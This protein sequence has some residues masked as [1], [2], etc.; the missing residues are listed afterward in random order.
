MKKTKKQ[1]L[2]PIEMERGRATSISSFLRTVDPANRPEEQTDRLQASLHAHQVEEIMRQDTSVQIAVPTQHISGL[3]HLQRKL[4]APLQFITS[5]LLERVKDSDPEGPSRNLS[6]E[7]QLVS[8]GWFPA[9][10]LIS[11]GGVFS[12]SYSFTIARAGKPGLEI[13][14]L[15]GLLLIFA[16]SLV[17]LLSTTPSRF[18]RITIVCMAGI[19]LYSIKVLASP[20]YFSFFDE[21]LHWRTA[22]DILHTGHLFN[23]NALL[24]VSPYYPGLEIV[25]NAL[26]TL[27]GLDTFYAA[28]IVIGFARLVM[29]LSLYLLNEQFTSSPRIAGL[30]TLLYMGNPHFL[31]FDAQYAYESLA[32]PLTEFVLLTLAPYQGLMIRLNQLK[33]IGSG[34]LSTKLRKLL[35]HNDLYGM[36]VTT[37]IVLATIVVTHHVTNF[38]LDGLL[39]LWASTYAFL[40][41]LPFYRSYLARVA[42]LGVILSC[43]MFLESGNP[44]INYISSFL[45]LAF[46]ELGHII[47]GTGGAKQLFQ[48][49]TGQ[50]TA[51]WERILTVVS[52]LLVIS[53]LPVGLLCL[54]QRFRTNAL[55]WTFGVLIFCYP[56]VQIFRFTTSG[57]ELVDRSAA[58]LFIPISTVVSIVIAQLWPVH[59]FSRIHTTSLTITLSIIIIGGIVLGAGPSLALLPGPYMVTA[60]ARSIET[61][62]IQAATW[63]KNYLGPNKR[64]A[65]DRINQIL[66][67]TYGDQ[68]II[69]SIADRVEIAPIFLSAQFGPEQSS[70]IKAAQARY[71]VVDMRLSKALPL[72]GFYYEQDEQGAY[73]H[74]QPLDAEDLKKF[75][76]IPQINKVFD[77]GSI[78]I[79]DAEGVLNA[80]EK[81]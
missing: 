41:P 28:L 63:T 11:S 56:L 19:N 15:L 12:V 3:D 10:A 68:Q 49:Y 58:F 78:V 26:S 8:W 71:L 64:I 50:P 52:Q 32:L 5:V 2:I 65:T 81:P 29:V 9:L 1:R 30:A 72:L 74:K 31:L 16:P 35:L 20:L 79:Y 54:W 4:P 77:S 62:G 59:R 55:A 70:L 76:A 27:T 75:A 57:S 25:T 33:I 43:A 40:R 22:N 47:T 51:L 44:V 66:M 21:F 69:T 7:K 38:F 80:P 60:D 13:F 39:V 45:L 34:T 42:L 53:A 14:F 46:Q 36:L 17:R 67:G 61:Q 48:S 24:P 73:K 37:L 23:S 18:E 6:G